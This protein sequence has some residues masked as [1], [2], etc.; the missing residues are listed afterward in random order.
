MKTYTW[1]YSDTVRVKFSAKQAVISTPDVLRP[2]RIVKFQ[3]PNVDHL[4]LY[5]AKLTADKMIELGYD[6]GGRNKVLAIKAMRD[7]VPFQ[8]VLSEIE[9]RAQNYSQPQGIRG[10]IIQIPL[11]SD[12]GKVRD[13]MNANNIPW[14]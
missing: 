7:N 3:H 5:N 13:F 11:A 6:L 4:G 12:F 9:A 10:Y 2:T 14:R 8:A 1:Q